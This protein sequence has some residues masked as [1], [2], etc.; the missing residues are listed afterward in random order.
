[1]ISYQYGAT[2]LVCP[3]H[4]MKMRLK[5][6]RVLRKDIFTGK[7]MFYRYSIT[8]MSYWKHRNG[9][10]AKTAHTQDKAQFMYKS[11]SKCVT[12]L[13][14]QPVILK[15]NSLNITWKC[16]YLQGL[17]IFSLKIYKSSKYTAKNIIHSKH[18]IDTAVRHTACDTCY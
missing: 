6:A 13:K 2:F 10:P 9:L 5:A 11:A 7:P 18:A 8:H 12:E 15:Y 3:V 4:S 17:Y 1:L 16:T 14:N